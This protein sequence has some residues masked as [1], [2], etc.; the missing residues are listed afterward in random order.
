MCVYMCG[1]VAG[2]TTGFTVTTTLKQNV[3]GAKIM[4]HFVDLIHYIHF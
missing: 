2:P 4:N 3:K 1:D